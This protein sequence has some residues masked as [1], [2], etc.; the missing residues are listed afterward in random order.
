MRL[1]GARLSPRP[2]RRAA[3]GE[4]QDADGAQGTRRRDG[5]LADQSSARLPDLRPGRGMRPAGPGHGLW[6]GFQPLQGEQARGRRQ[7]CRA[8]GQ[9]HHES[10]H[11]L[12][13]LRAVH[14]RSRGRAGTRGHRSRRGYR[15]HD[16]PRTGDDLGIAGQRGR[17]LSG[18]RADLQALRL[19]RAAMG[20]GQDRVGRCHGRGRLGYP[21]RYARARGH[22]HPSARQRRCERGVDFRQD[23]P[24]R[25]RPAR[26]AP[27]PTLRSRGRPALSSL[28]A[29]CIRCHRREGQADQPE[30]YGCHCRRSRS[31]RGNLR[32]QGPDDAARGRQPRLPAGW[33]RGRS[34]MG[35]GEL[36]L[37]RDHFRHR[38]SRRIADRRLQSAARGR[39]AQRT[40]P[41]A[42][43]H[44]CDSHRHDRR[45]GRISPI[46]TTIS[47]R[48]RRPWRMSRAV[49]TSSARC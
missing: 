4:H 14:D 30:A 13:A 44:R 6:R 47:A 23:P 35:E 38:E 43:A 28:V 31:S 21:H 20:A 26:P 1:G 39:R 36:P 46:L 29:G 9:D 37:Q 33:C 24:R 41:Q 5:V 15:D 11:S 7:V 45:A 10:L 12:H 18:R 48:G 27:R 40:Y 34:K 17:S 19:R 49:P 22:A 32:A 8:S 16:L 3:R 2:Q 42:L 25:R